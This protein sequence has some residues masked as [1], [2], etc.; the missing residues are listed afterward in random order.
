M[1]QPS[2]PLSR[3]NLMR[4]SLRP[5]GIQL[6]LAGSSKS[7]ETPWT[8]RKINGFWEV[9]FNV[10]D[11]PIYC[12]SKAMKFGRQS[13][14]FYQLALPELFQK[15]GITGA[16]TY[17]AQYQ[18]VLPVFEYCRL[19]NKPIFADMVELF[20][21]KYRYFLNGVNFQEWLL[22]RRLLPCFDGLIGISHYWCDWAKGKGVPSVLVPSFAEDK[23]WVRSTQ[24][25]IDKPFT[26]TFIGHWVERELPITLLRAMRLCIDQGIPIELNV[27]GNV[28]KSRWE[29][30]AMHFLKGDS[31][32]QANVHF[33]GFVSD[34]ERDQHLVNADA[35]VVLRKKCRET[36][37]MFPT[38]LPE[39]MLTGNPVIISEVGSFSKCFK[40]KKDVWFISKEN[41]PE[42]LA[43]AFEY[44]ATHS[45][46]RSAIGRLGRVSALN[47]FSMDVLGKRLASFIKQI[48][49]NYN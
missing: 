2:A 41:R 15:M 23:G 38:R 12:H 27:L 18:T 49:K 40:H 30:K 28:G 10:K 11:F 43:E 36:D 19:N 6:I 20:D 47:Q 24:S 9:H 7:V 32:L 46:E 45:E 39:Y 17:S 44:L 35:F 33:L 22:I 21:W 1:D 13:A 34:D 14:K 16:I 31:V 25:P 26:I 3:L 48:V 29:R 5:H 8:L 42:D 37:A 4:L